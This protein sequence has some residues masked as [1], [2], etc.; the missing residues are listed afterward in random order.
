MLSNHVTR[1]Y[2]A[3]QIPTF[4][5]N[6]YYI[7]PLS[8]LTR[9]WCYFTVSTWHVRYYLSEC[10]PKKGETDSETNFPPHFLFWLNITSSHHFELV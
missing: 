6:Y 10:L 4:S 1:T 9:S 2:V 7:L 3:S 5:Q 8:M